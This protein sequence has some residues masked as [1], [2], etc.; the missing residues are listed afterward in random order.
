MRPDP[1]RSRS[2]YPWVLDLFQHQ[3]AQLDVAYEATDVHIRVTDTPSV[4]GPTSETHA[5]LSADGTV[6]LGVCSAPPGLLLSPAGARLI[7]SMPGVDE[8]TVMDDG[9]VLVLCSA[10]LLEQLPAGFR[11]GIDDPNSSGVPELLV[12]IRHLT[13]E[14][15]G[16]AV[17]AS[18]RPA[19]PGRGAP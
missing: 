10:G 6:R 11:T 2:G 8:G 4:D 13:D 15:A 17:V 14:G 7:P 16:S 19:D 3:P 12:A 5:R 1:V 9:D 18:W